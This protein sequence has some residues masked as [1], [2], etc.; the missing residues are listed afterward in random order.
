MTLL[1]G[2]HEQSWII[3][4]FGC[5][6][7]SGS[8]GSDWFFPSV[9][10][11]RCP[12]WLCRHGGSIGTDCWWVYRSLTRPRPL[13]AGYV[14]QQDTGSREPFGLLVTTAG[15][16]VLLAGFAAVVNSTLIGPF[17]RFGFAGLIGFYFL[18]VA[19]VEET[20]KWLAIRLH[21]YRRDEFSAVI[22]GAVYGAMAGFGFAT[23][24]NALYIVQQAVIGGWF[25]GD[26]ITLSVTV[27]RSLAGP[28]HV[29]YSAFA[30]YYLGLAKF[31]PDNRKPII[32]KGLLIATGAHALYNTGVTVLPGILD[33]IP[34][35]SGV[36]VG[37]AF[38][39]FVIVYDGLLLVVLL[40]KLH[41]YRRAFEASGAIDRP[42]GPK[43]T[44]D[45]AADTDGT[46]PIE[47]RDD[48]G[49]D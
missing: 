6:V 49:P 3:P 36:S 10:P 33:S 21:A 16:G 29:I 24:E 7:P 48:D 42:S 25:A 15:L 38:V 18:V 23:I 46:S 11:H 37:V 22:D 8:A 40:G 4:L 34:A 2:S 28:G 44:N 45:D 27:I 47:E 20:V 35:L 30:G 19:P 1:A 9:T 43:H 17:S 32:V 12:N 41:R 13:L 31:N 5:R 26:S 39:V 14:R